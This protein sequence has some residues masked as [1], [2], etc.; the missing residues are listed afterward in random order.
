MAI[1]LP[2]VDHTPETWPQGVRQGPPNWPEAPAGTGEMPEFPERAPERKDDLFL[3]FVD[4]L[5]MPLSLLRGYIRSVTLMPELEE[6]GQPVID[7]TRLTACGRIQSFQRTIETGRTYCEGANLFF[8]KEAVI[9]LAERGVPR[10]LI[11]M[12]ARELIADLEDAERPTGIDTDYRY[13]PQ[14]PE[15]IAF[16]KTLEPWTFARVFWDDLAGWYSGYDMVLPSELEFTDG[17]EQNTVA[18]ALAV[19]YATDPRLSPERERCKFMP[20]VFYSELDLAEED[21]PGPEHQ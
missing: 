14:N 10:G 3:A 4:S 7:D 12:E 11:P 6:L 16:W 20:S 8:L 5:L 9:G 2:P 13:R 21:S 17:I 15:H 19:L 1:L 18:A